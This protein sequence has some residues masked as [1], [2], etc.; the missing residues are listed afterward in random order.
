MLSKPQGLS[1][2]GKIRAIEKKFIDIIG[3][4]FII[5][6]IFCP[7]VIG[8][9]LE[10]RPAEQTYLL[11]VPDPFQ[12]ERCRTIAVQQDHYRPKLFRDIFA[13]LHPTDILMPPNRP[14]PLYL[15]TLNSDIE[16]N[17]LTSFNSIFED[18]TIQ[19]TL[20]RSCCFNYTVIFHISC[21]HSNAW[22]WYSSRNLSYAVFEFFFVNPLLFASCTNTFS[23]W[24]KVTRGMK[25]SAQ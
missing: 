21:F 22:S 3:N 18:L 13:T 10:C 7:T 14:L 12:R 17:F 20:K 9:L 8:Y 11:F 25:R 15:Q 6:I 19:L 1:A 4:I 2:S 16:N 5:M 24:C 23:K